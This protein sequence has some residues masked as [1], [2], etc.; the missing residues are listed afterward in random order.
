MPEMMG[1]PSGS[2][3]TV[4]GND[5]ARGIVGIELHGILN[6]GRIFQIGIIKKRIGEIPQRFGI[7]TFFMFFENFGSLDSQRTV[8]EYLLL[9]ELFFVDKEIEKI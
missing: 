1:N 5:D 9:R 7:I 4:T 6:A 3:H 2:A 8:E